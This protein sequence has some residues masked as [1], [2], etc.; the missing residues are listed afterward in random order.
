M[1]S[2]PIADVEADLTKAKFDRR[3]SS[4]SYLMRMP[5]H[6]LTKEMY[7]KLMADALKATGA[8]TKK[9][10]VELGLRTLL[11]MSRQAEVRRLR[12]KVQWQGD[13]DAMRRDK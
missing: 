6:S 11:Q 12:G 10:A 2:R 7:D 1:N 8:K 13:L 9:E 3:D 4:Y 5:I